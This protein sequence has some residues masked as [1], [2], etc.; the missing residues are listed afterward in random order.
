[1]F[2]HLG[3][4]VAMIAA[5]VGFSTTT[6][7][8]LTDDLI[9]YWTFDE[10]S[11]NRAYDSGSRGYDGILMYAGSGVT[12]VPG[13][14]GTAVRFAGASNYYIDCGTASRN[15]TLG[16]TAMT[17]GFWARTENDDGCILSNGKRYSDYTGTIVASASDS[18]SVYAG[19]GHG[20]AIGES[21]INEEWHYRT[22]VWGG[23][24]AGTLGVS[25]RDGVALGSTSFQAGPLPASDNNLRFGTNPDITSDYYN[26]QGAVDEM[27]IWNRALTDDEVM[28]AY[29]LGLTG[30]NLDWTPPVPEPAGLGLLGLGLLGVAPRKKRS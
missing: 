8:E 15:I 28:E 27:A 3:G 18:P 21:W 25:Y 9:C 29:T 2:R 16:S 20:G 10:G 14:V 17:I 7:A 11:G 24:S 6:A 22:V 1:M 12:W 23:N 4:F 30:R 13:A 5:L 26:Y 19:F